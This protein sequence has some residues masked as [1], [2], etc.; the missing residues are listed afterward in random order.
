LTFR[1]D[2]FLL[3]SVFVEDQV[4]TDIREKDADFLEARRLPPHPATEPTWRSVPHECIGLASGAGS[5]APAALAWCC[6]RAQP[7]RETT[8]AR[9][10]PLL[11]QDVEVFY[12]VVEYRKRLQNRTR[13]VVRE[14]LFPSY[15]FARFPMELTKQVRF[16]QGVAS[17]VMRGKD[18]PAIV[19]QSV[20]DELFFLAPSGVIKLDFPALV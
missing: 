14:S 20:M 16:T 2:Q 6:I 17:I 8:A 18:E 3:N 11:G 5:A 9:L 15:L 19:P 10:L 7:R 13:R 1:E 4:R 12:P